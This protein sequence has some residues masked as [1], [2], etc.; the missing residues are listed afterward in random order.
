MSSDFLNDIQCHETEKD[1]SEVP[2]SC[3][4]IRR[5]IFGIQICN[6]FLDIVEPNTLV[7]M[8]LIGLFYQL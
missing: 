1:D 5:H 7:I 8:R 4:F 6:S 3:A 2:V